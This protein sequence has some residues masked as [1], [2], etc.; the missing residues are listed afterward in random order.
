[1]ECGAQLDC[2]NVRI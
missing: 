2:L 1:L